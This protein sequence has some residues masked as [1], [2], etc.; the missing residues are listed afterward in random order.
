[1]KVIITD[2]NCNC[3]GELRKFSEFFLARK[4]KIIEENII[5][6]YCYKIQKKTNTNKSKK[7][8][9]IIVHPLFKDWVKI[10]VTIDLIKR[11]KSFQAC[12]PYRGFEV[13]F[14]TGLTNKHYEFELYFKKYIKSNNYEWFNIER[15]EAKELVE[16][17]WRIKDNDNKFYRAL[18][19]NKFFQTNVEPLKTN[20]F[21]QNKR[22]KTLSH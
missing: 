14:N 7:H 12:C 4:A 17:L 10:G 9:Y 18:Y 3:C 15:E 20:Y 8:I 6:D 5:C 22:F 19:Q 13:Y 21:S 2:K 11:L 16:Q 1:M